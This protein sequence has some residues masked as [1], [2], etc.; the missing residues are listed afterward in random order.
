M[1][2]RI[3]P[4]VFFGLLVLL[5]SFHQPARAA[6]DLIKFTAQYEDLGDVLQR[7]QA[8]SGIRLVYVNSVVD[9]FRVFRRFQD[10]PYEAV[11]KAL[12]GTPLDF[13]RES[14]ELWVI[15][16]KKQTRSL[17]ATV[18][19]RVLDIHLGQGIAGANV[20]V[21]ESNLGVTTDG[22]GFFELAGIPPG[23]VS[24][25][26]RR[27]G[28]HEQ[29]L[30]I[31]IPGNSQRRLE[32]ALEPKPISTREVVVEETTY[33]KENVPVLSLQRIDRSQL[34]TPPLTND[35]EVFEVLHQ[36][37]GVSRRDLDD[38][39]PHVEG[40]SATEV[41][42]ELDGMPIY[43]PT[44]GQNRRSVFAAPALES[45]TL[46]RAGYG[47]E[48]GDAMSGIISLKTVGFDDISMLTQGSASLTGLFFNFSKTHC[49]Q[50][51]SR[52]YPYKELTVHNCK[53]RR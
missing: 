27:I 25:S 38:V 24:L 44:F 13:I 21:E 51:M 39:F 2:Q 18:T 8:E 3:L 5:V 9:S 11:R 41:A 52:Y 15:V 35:G 6:R 12:I 48:Y 46:R 19:G 34:Q 7:I 30:E 42:V 47:A 28:Y 17:P 4:K 22:H 36:L 50:R 26:F 45:V 32:V 29:D 20:F 1:F 43:V 16:P 10:T 37:P 23:R 31:S 33:P 14:D 53:L 49:F 40:G